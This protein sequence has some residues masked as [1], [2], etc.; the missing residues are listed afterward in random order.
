MDKRL[1]GFRLGAAVLALLLMLCMCA[2][3]CA[4]ADPIRVS[5]LS[6]PQS[7]ISE[8]DVSITI[9][10]YNS[11]QTDMLDEITLFNPLGVSV[12]KYS[13]LKGEQSVT[14]TGK[15]H[16]TK[17]QIEKGKINYYIQYTVDTGSGPQ[18]ATRTVPVTI[19][20]EEAA[21]QLTATY[22]VSPA[23]AREGQTVTLSYTLSNTGNVE[24]RN[25]VIENDGVSKEELAQPSLSV[26]EKVTLTDSF[27]MGKKELVSKPSITYQ[28][29]E[30][31][32][33]LTISDL[34]RKTI[35]V[36]EDG[37]EIYLTGKNTENVYPGEKIALTIELKN[38][39]NAAY[40]G[41]S[42]V[43][44]DGTAVASGVE[45]A[46]G[47]SVKKEIEWTASE[48]TALTASVSGS[49]S[50]GEA[51]A[52][53]SGELNITTQD[54]SR[55]LMLNI[56]ADVAENVIHSEPAV[57]RFGVVVENIGETDAATLTIEQ[58][59]TTVAKI[60]SL[61]AGE[62]R[63]V[64]FDLETSI[65]G[66]FQFVVKGRDA[67]GNERAYESNILQVAY[68]APTPTPTAVPTPTPVPPTPTPVPTA[69]P[70]PTL[71]E[72]IAEKVDPV[73]LYSIAGALAALL[74]TVLG[75]S[76]VTSA[77]RKKRMAQAIDTIELTPD[78]RNHRGVAR[79]RRPQANAKPETAEA[80]EEELVL[81]Q[82]EH[83]QHEELEMLA[84]LKNA[85]VY[86]AEQLPEREEGRR[87]RNAAFEVPGDETLRVMPVD[88]R[89]EF[90]AQGRVDDSQ[91]RIFSGLA[92]EL[93]QAE[94]R[95]AKE[96][97]VETV[98]KVA[99]LFAEAQDI[100]MHDEPSDSEAEQT[101]RLSREQIEEIR[102]KNEQPREDKYAGRGRKKDEIKPMKKQK[103]GFLFGRK[104]AKEEDEDDFFEDFAE[105]EDY[106]DE[107]L[108]E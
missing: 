10:I 43:L 34:A 54:A 5:S 69:T 94:S 59:G 70:A 107:D 76:G 86:E 50:N 80:Q 58:A 95:N 101:I 36:A 37:L 83:A 28:A 93:A 30:S 65:A 51:V 4:D 88:Q 12:E 6:E 57:V 104:K 21:P 29:A 100:M 7:V 41:L 19:Q 46:A 53:V 72:I 89:P 48:N 56:Y 60:P 62:S 105:G 15:W 98:N 106:D 102:Q 64:V 78:V 9:K 20:T 8:Q 32:K 40:K 92:G 52:V 31:N 99:D 108:F 82:A 91:T 23:S 61:P 26:G 79:R 42:A 85:P 38:T 90:I 49:D 67:D 39:G 74:V 75:V 47:A 44:S 103:K 27:K 11:S 35:T 13:G 45:L 68:V 18:K 97:P 1:K 14:Y 71:G 63:T 96:P 22:S 33:K 24:L 55:A 16:V 25:I 84:E 17:E 81:P 3:A 66:K 73:V 87:R 77:R 2:A